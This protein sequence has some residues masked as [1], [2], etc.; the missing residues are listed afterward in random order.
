MVIAPLHIVNW[1]EIFRK[2][3]KEVRK[4]AAARQPDAGKFAA[5]H[6]ISQFAPDQPS[7]I[8]LYFPIG[9]ELDTW[10]LAEGLLALGHTIAL[11]VVEKKSA[12]LK[13]RQFTPDAPLIEGA[14]G[15]QHPDE[16]AREVTPDIIVTPLLGV[17]R[18]GARLGMGG[19]YYDRTLSAA[20]KDRDVT[21]IGYGYA[22]QKID[23]FPVDDHDQFL[24]G[25]ASEQGAERFTRRR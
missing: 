12:P 19:G 22:A 5:Q 11:P 24:D 10:P 16:S 13:F 25:F 15:T 23:R 18:D 14:Y 3:A 6:F 8:A 7:T 9:D 17:R 1:K 21:A 20:R 2:R 4:T